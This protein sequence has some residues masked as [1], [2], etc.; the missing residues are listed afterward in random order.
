M[1]TPPIRITGRLTGVILAVT[2]SCGAWVQAQAPSARTAI[3]GG[4][5][6]GPSRESKGRPGA[7]ELDSEIDGYL[8]DA[9]ERRRFTGVVLVAQDGKP[10]VRRAYAYADATKR[11]PNTPETSFMI[12]SNTKQFTAAAILILQ[13]RGSLCVKDAI[14]K[15]LPDCPP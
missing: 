1:R 12:F 11:V 9:V 7:G 13:D 14:G 8:R 5:T 2:G 15:Y 4:A 10:L 6:D 3:T